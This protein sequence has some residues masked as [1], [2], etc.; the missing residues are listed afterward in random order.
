MDKVNPSMK[1]KPRKNKK[2]TEQ[3]QYIRDKIHFLKKE[4]NIDLTPQEFVHMYELK[5]E[6]AVDNFAKTLIY[7]KLSD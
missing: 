6:I 2:L 4:F 7:N 3:E 5:S 1:K